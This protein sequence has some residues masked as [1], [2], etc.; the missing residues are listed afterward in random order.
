MLH[1]VP[2][3]VYTRLV[4]PAVFDEETCLI[5]SLPT[6]ITIPT[7]IAGIPI[8]PPIVPPIPGLAMLPGF[9]PILKALIP[10]IGDMFGLL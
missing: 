6:Y 10:F 9:R 7:N 3:P 2:L 5:T 1:V 8:D 4:V